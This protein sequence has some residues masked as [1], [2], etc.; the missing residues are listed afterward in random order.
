VTILV[1]VDLSPASERT[2]DAV[3]RWM[4]RAS[5]RVVVV[6]VAAPD[7]EFVGWEAGPGA[8]RDQVAREF[9]RE[10]HDVERLAASLRDDGI[11]ATGLTVQGPTVAT[12]LAEADR[13]GADLIA[14]GSH[15]HGAAYGLVVG[16]ISAEIIRKATM[17]VLV[18]P[19]REGH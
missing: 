4:P 2:L 8:V 16:S 1:A 17:P 18:V 9:R 5:L 15:G 19:C 7:P 11:E 10:R 14:V 13:L 6:H 12:V 3:R